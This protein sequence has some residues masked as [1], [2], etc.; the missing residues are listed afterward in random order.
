MEIIGLLMFVLPT[1][2][3]GGYIAIEVFDLDGWRL[4]VSS[5]VCGLYVAVAMVL[6]MGDKLP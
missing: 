5:I 6:I 3:M 1:V 4:T 2:I